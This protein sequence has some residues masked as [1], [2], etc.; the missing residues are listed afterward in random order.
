MVTMR[1]ICFPTD[2]Y[3]GWQLPIGK[4]MFILKEYIV[5]DDMWYVTAE[6]AGEDEQENKSR[7]QRPQQV[8]TALDH[9]ITQKGERRHKICVAEMMISPYEYGPQDVE[10]SIREWTRLAID[11][12]KECV[13]HSVGWAIIEDDYIAYKNKVGCIDSQ[14]LKKNL[15]G[16]MINGNTITLLLFYVKQDDVRKHCFTLKTLWQMNQ[17]ASIIK[18]SRTITLWAQLQCY[19]NLCT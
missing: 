4:A 5:R 2:F 14:A 10:M 13:N 15:Q 19:G 16:P 11:V 12:D 9:P 18:T 6:E 17:E 8:P 7:I 1:V 3:W